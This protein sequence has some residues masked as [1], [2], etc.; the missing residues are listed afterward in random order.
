[1]KRNIVNVDNW[2]SKLLPD[3]GF[4]ATTSRVVICVAPIMDDLSR[5]KVV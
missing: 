5:V 2:S 3:W 4:S 1:M